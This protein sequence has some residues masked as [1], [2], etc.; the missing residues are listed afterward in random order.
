MICDA[1]RQT[2]LQLLGELPSLQGL[3]LDLLLVTPP[4]P[5]QG[6]YALPTFALA[7]P[8]RRAPAA[9]ASEVA[10]QARQR[11][12][13]YPAIAGV[14]AV[15]PFVN[16]T[17]DPTVR[18]RQTLA[19]IAAQGERYGCSDAGQGRVVAIDFSSPNIAKPFGIGHLRST[20][21]GSALCNLYRSQ[22]YQPHGVNHVGD[23]GKQVGMLM[24]ALSERADGLGEL[25]R[26]EDPISFLLELY[27]GV[28]QRAAQEPQVE[29]RARDWFVALE[30][31]DAA[32]RTMWQRCVSV[33]MQEFERIY[34]LLGVRANLTHVWGE[35]HYEGEPLQR[36]IRELEQR[37]LLVESE[38]ARVVF[39]DGDLPPC[40]ILKKDGATLYA[41][42][43]LA[44]A[45]YRQETLAAWRL[46]YV[47]G[48][49]PALHFRQVFQVLDK[50][51]Y[52]WADNCLHVPFGHIRL[53]EGAMSTR[54]GNIILL[55]EVLRRAIALVDGIVSVRDYP[56]EERE[57]IARAVGIGAV[58]FADLS[59]SRQRDWE[60]RWED[61]LNFSGRTGPYLQYTQARLGSVLRKYGQEVPTSFDPARLADPEAQAVLRQLG[62]FPAVVAAALEAH[63]PSVVSR[64]LLD[65][66]EAQNSFYNAQRIL[67]AEQPE[68]SAARIALIAAVRT[69]LVNGLKLLGIPVPPR[70]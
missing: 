19:T 34:D 29:Q 44:A 22:G 56:A 52:A 16:L 27:V 7:K 57:A 69:V 21:I 25:E 35:S 51:G 64:Y 13:A 26:A 59:G 6:D 24:V 20:V 58:I 55:D 49:P 42:R 11:L 62:L 14:E 68:T 45:I 48:A 65:L 8:L 31:G 38:D 10:E 43:D 15:G 30:R 2:A 3:D 28:N 41:T 4:R 37:G 12:A 50:L 47:V 53:P 1:F 9:I 18:A 60:F 46:V 36:V 23:W 17:I 63:E 54:K 61:L 5:E 40:L 32:A 33:S 39:L 70:M 66:A 67:D